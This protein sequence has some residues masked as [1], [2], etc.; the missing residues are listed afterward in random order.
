MA[1][2]LN[3]VIDR[4]VPPAQTG[5]AFS[6]YAFGIVLTAVAMF[7]TVSSDSL[8]S[9]APFILAA[10]AVMLA[11]WRGGCGPGIVSGLI[12]LLAVNYFIL[13]PTG[14]LNLLTGPNAVTAVLFLG[15][16]AMIS[17]LNDARLRAESQQAKLLSREQAA[18]VRYRAVFDGVADAILVVDGDRRFTDL[19]T[20]ALNLLGYTKEEL[21]GQKTDVV[22]ASG[23]EW[24]ATEFARFQ[25]EGK[26]NGE[27]SLTRRN[28]TSVPVEAMATVVDLPEGR[29]NLSALRDI[30]ERLDA[31]R[32]QHAFLESVSHDL[33]NPLAS[34]KL[35]VQLLRRRLLAGNADIEQIIAALGTVDRA[36]IRM[37]DQLDE[38]QDVARLRSGQQLELKLVRTDLAALVRQAV[39]D[40]QSTAGRL[41]FTF[42]SG[43]TAPTGDWDPIRLRRVIDNVLSNA[44][45][46]SPKGGNIIVTVSRVSVGD[47][48][49][50]RIEICD[51]GTGIPAA[52]LPLIFDRYRRGSNVS[53]AIGGSGIGLFGVRQIVEG[54]GGR[55]AVESQEGAGSL[56]RIDL[57]LM[58]QSID[59]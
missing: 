31:L 17:A 57:P 4:F 30:S 9:R 3:A 32:Q 48:D 54:H 55:I 26:W 53:T 58:R 18:E 27:L 7:I 22:V 2:K 19:N 13:E 5:G 59:S 8:S 36:M 40:A 21:I 24:S 23:A 29:I 35:Q 43:G 1:S 16:A 46:Y 44:V 42:V 45:K 51:E 56:V 15:V 37:S 34:A 52:D 38:L 14:N 28:G 50:A 12:S 20:A 25:T 10:A 33:K 6:R 39:T 47:Q 41:Q 49:S 11:S